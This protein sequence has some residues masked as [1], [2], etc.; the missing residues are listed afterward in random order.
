MMAV[1]VSGVSGHQR[2]QERKYACNIFFYIL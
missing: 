1:T 2:V